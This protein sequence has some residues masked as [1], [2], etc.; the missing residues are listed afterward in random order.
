MR[1]QWRDAAI[2]GATG[3]I[4]KM[5]AEAQEIDNRDRYGQTALMLSAMHGRAAAVELLIEKRACVKDI[6]K[7]GRTAAMLAAID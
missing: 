1:K 4:K 3:L 6:A 5:L 7:D 2:G